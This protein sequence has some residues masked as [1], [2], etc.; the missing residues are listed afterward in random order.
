[1]VVYVPCHYDFSQ[2]EYVAPFLER[3]HGSKI[4]IYKWNG[5]REKMREHYQS[6]EYKPYD[7]GVHDFSLENIVRCA[8]QE[9]PGT[10]VV[11]LSTASMAYAFGEYMRQMLADV[12]AVLGDRIWGFSVVG[13]CMYGCAS[14][15]GND[16]KV[17]VYFTRYFRKQYVHFA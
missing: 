3:Y 11:F 16:H 9:K 1:M 15:K 14:C 13:H 17:P 8:L 7:V 12:K 5:L 10:Q 6:D 4:F 2:V